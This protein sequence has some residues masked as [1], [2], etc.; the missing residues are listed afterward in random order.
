MIETPLPLAPE[1]GATLPA[2]SASGLEPTT[3]N[4]YD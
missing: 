1:V 3:V 2:A 4:A